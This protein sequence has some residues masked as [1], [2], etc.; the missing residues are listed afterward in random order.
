MANKTLKGIGQLFSDYKS[1]CKFKGTSFKLDLDTFSTLV[2]QHCF[3]CGDPPTTIRRNCT[4]TRYK[5]K[6]KKY[7]Y[8]SSPLQGLDRLNPK[9]GYMPK[10]V[11]PC[12]PTCNYMKQSQTLSQFLKHV[13]KVYSNLFKKFK[14]GNTDGT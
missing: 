8:V 2:I 1:H 10:N 3:Y 7:N 9:K 5:G 12:C 11:V 6:V 13:N 4:V 14:S